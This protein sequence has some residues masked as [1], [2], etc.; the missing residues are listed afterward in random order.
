MKVLLATDCYLFQ[1]GGV[2]GAVLALESGLRKEGCEV[3]VLALSD[4]RRS[5][6]DGDSYFLRSCRFPDY[7]EHRI[8]FARHDPLLDELI[9]W[10]PD[11][12]HI[13]TEASAGWKARMIAEKTDTPIIMTTH[14]DFEYFNFGR[15][16]SALPV[17]MLAMAWGRW[18]YRQAEAIVVPAEKARAFAHLRPYA[19]RVV[20]IPNGIRLERCQKPVS[21]DEKEALLGKYSLLDNGCTLIMVTRLS[22]EKNILEILRYFPSLLREIPDAQLLIVGEGPD[23]KRLESCC[24]DHH[25]GVH[26]RFTGRIPPDEVYRYYALGDIF[27]SASTFELHSISCLEATACGLPLVCREDSSLQGVLDDGENGLIYRNEQEFVGAVSRIL[28]SDQLRGHMRAG[29]LLRAEKNSDQ[30][31]AERTLGLYHSVC[32]SWSSGVSRAGRKGKK[33]K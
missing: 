6:R 22:R 15:F 32:E 33:A 27:V 23:R 19:D 29:A 17:R 28:G 20:V 4:S 31:F 5:Y 10:N 30:C 25:L 12:V 14:T 13:H 8:T 18:T 21:R 24:M 2:T 7:P 26:V 16:R 11:L 9:A 1:T 3:K